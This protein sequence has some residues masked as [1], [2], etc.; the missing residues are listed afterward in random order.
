MPSLMHVLQPTKW[1][2]SLEFFKLN[3]RKLLIEALKKGPIP[4]HVAFVMDGNRTFARM[5]GIET[6]EGHRFGFG[7]FLEIIDICFRTGIKVV[8]VYAFSTENFK[9]SKSEVD[10]LMD[11]LKVKL[12]EMAEHGGLLERYGVKV[13]FP[14]QL[15]LLRPD[16]LAIVNRTIEMTGQNLDRT[17]NI[18]CPYTSRNEIVTAIRDTIIDYSTNKPPVPGRTALPECQASALN[19]GAQA[20]V[21]IYGD[22]TQR[23]EIP[24]WIATTGSNGSAALDHQDVAHFKVPA[25]AGPEKID[26]Q[27]LTDH[28]W[29][30]GNPP[31]NILIRTSGVRR[32][33]DFMLWQCCQATEVVYLDVLWPDFSFWHFLAVLVGWQAKA[34]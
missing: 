8:T 2:P 33:S 26:E 24:R 10:G 7:A 23:I 16:V 15:D 13:V 20:C 18:C 21:S 19:A 6:L 1:F 32:L 27:A 25:F 34:S 31:L 30:K 3:I 29:T 4:N 17:L 12:S 11:L 5:H 9:R 28:L 22:S 14:G